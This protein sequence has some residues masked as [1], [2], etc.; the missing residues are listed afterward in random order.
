MLSQQRVL[1]AGICKGKTSS[2]LQAFL[3]LSGGPFE[4]GRPCPHEADR[5]PRGQGLA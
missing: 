5:L 4:A 1:A 3:L 2:V